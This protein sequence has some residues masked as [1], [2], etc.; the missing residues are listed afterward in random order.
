M[1][2]FEEE[3]WPK[4]LI[5]APMLVVRWVVGLLMD[6]T[7]FFERCM[8][9]LVGL[10]YRI[11]D[12][13]DEEDERL[14]QED[15]RLVRVFRIFFRIFRPSNLFYAPLCLMR[16]FV[17]LLMDLTETFDRRL[18][19]VRYRVDEVGESFS[20]ADSALM[21]LFR[22][23]TFPF[24][25]L[26]F[27]VLS[28]WGRALSLNPIFQKI[29]AATYWLW[30]P[31]K[32]WAWFLGTF[33][34]TRRQALV[35][36]FFPLVLLILGTSAA[37]WMFFPRTSAVTKKY[38][39]AIEA[40]IAK[41]DYQQ[42]QLYQDKLKTLGIRHNQDEI[43]QIE[44]LTKQGKIDEAKAMA[45]RLA[46]LDKPGL[47]EA[48]FWLAQ[49]YLAEKETLTGASS[50]ERAEL[51]LKNLEASLADLKVDR[52][53]PNAVLLS[54]MLEFKKKNPKRGLS[55]LNSVSDRYWPAMVLQLEVHADLGQSKELIQDAKAISQ[56]IKKEPLILDEVSAE[57]FPMWCSALAAASEPEEY[58][59]SVMHWVRKHPKD[60]RAIVAW[61]KLQFSEIDTLMVRGSESDLARATKVLV[62]TTNR[63][64]YKHH[65]VV[66]TW[67]YE[68]LPPADNLPNYQRLI[69]LAAQD[70]NTSS[71]LFEI[72]GTAAEMRNDPQ[73]ARE[74]LLRATA[75]DPR[76][77][78]ALNNLAYVISLHFPEEMPLALELAQTAAQLQ[79][80]DTRV[81]HTRGFI[82]LRLR[83]WDSAIN[84]FRKVLAR[85]PDAKDIHLGLAQA[86]R[87]IGQA[88]LAAIH[89]NQ[90]K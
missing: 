3:S 12:R 87:A 74:L 13:T 70:E 50:L 69:E 40:A 73:T 66:S 28:P 83:Q 46:P 20:R 34:Q 18:Q 75:K 58:K 68:K 45:E 47:P 49:F 7:E 11:T 43:R 57:F 81:L 24:V 4:K 42:A 17:G 76:N 77:M 15:S 48:H 51:H 27:R 61:A 23:L 30:Y 79:P 9:A 60:P 80:E 35:L 59:T 2:D 84:D 55:L 10:F 8:M 41:G 32:A 25:W 63:L 38:R 6:A 56:M 86:Y 22:I 39:E 65:F 29:G 14:I 54:A 89:E 88:D 62:Q 16:W 21:R 1:N 85:T 78:I 82:Y 5:Q 37:V 36:W 26:W 71:L 33:F 53:P 72:L 52:L 31:L 90:S 19:A 67:L 64:D 44:E